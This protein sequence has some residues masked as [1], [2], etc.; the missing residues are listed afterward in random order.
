MTMQ[1][2]QHAR[3]HLE[4]VK[5]YAPY[6]IVVL[7]FAAGLFALHR[8]LAPID[9]RAVAVEVRTIPLLTLLGAFI[10]TLGGYGA[11][12][13]YDWSALRYI[14]KTLPLRTVMLGGFLGYAFGN[15]IG[16]NA[17]SGGAVRYRIYSAL[18][19]DG[20]DVAAIATFASLAY[21]FGAC[22]V[23]L[24]SLAI[25]PAALQTLLPFDP[26]TIRAAAAVC[27]ALLVLALGGL[28]FSGATIKIWRVNV[29]APSP[30]VMAG[31]V[32]FTMLDLGLSSLALYMLLPP[33]ELGFA[34]F[35]AVFC[36]ATMI[37]VL[38]HVP[39][40][41]GV[42]E[43]V[44]L[45]SLPAS[46]PLD[47]AAAALLVFR[48]IYY[49]VPFG[50]ALVL[51]A[52]SE[53][54]AAAPAMSGRMGGA[55]AAM[56]PAA[57]AASAVAPAAL[58]ALTFA[59][60][61]WMLVSALM[62]TMSQR[63]DELELLVPPMFVEGGALLSSVIGAILIIVAHGLARRIADAY[64][65]A[66]IALAAGAAT[67][68]LH[69]LD[70]DR[71]IALACAALILLP[72]RREFHRSA[73][74]THAPF[75]PSWFAL[76]GAVAVSAA[77][78]WFFAH[79][80]AGREQEVWWLLAFD[81]TVP[82]AMRAGL[83]ASLALTAGLVFFALR[84]VTLAPGR[85]TPQDMA[86]AGRII[87]GQPN[88]DAN[89]AFAGDKALMFAEKRDAFVMYAVQNRSWIAF[90]DPV[91]ARDGAAQAAWAFAD[92]ATYAGARPV[93]YEVSEA[94]LPLWIDMG[95]ALHKIGEE[96]VVDLVAF[97]LDGPARKRLRT[98]WNRARRDGL[99]FTMLAPPHAPE[100]LAVLRAIS[101]R[102]LA[103][104]KTREKGF[105]VGRFDPDYLDRFSIM[106]VR[107]RGRPVAFA[108]VI[109]TG[110]RLKSAIDLMRH[111]PDAP[112]GVM[113]FLFTALM[114]HQK[115]EGVARFSLGMA[116]L[117]GLEA[118]RG[119]SL[120]TQFGAQIYRHG[121]HFYNFEGLRHFKEKFD[122]EWRPRYLACESTLPPV[123]PLA[124]VS[125]L[126][127]GGARGVIGR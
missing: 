31:Q 107:E 50:I 36:I 41:V 23:G 27:L 84:P 12:I 78:L 85:P 67:A 60:G 2:G 72:C 20:Y 75:D 87:A 93:F 15:T 11:L 37:G 54:V 58:A 119:A 68:L 6:V 14:R 99:D 82:R 123:K 32:G 71:A 103:G 91:G 48:L 114:L 49:L 30:A 105:S 28:A 94:F 16:L 86:D 81:D 66:Q 53:L 70:Y 76:I 8:L 47:Q 40:G 10:A 42:F 101:D 79:K 63:A 33:S 29:R 120:W 38:S 89:L 44:V 80:G 22:V 118:R 3:P 51:L 126:I 102:W 46:I 83:L 98:A 97:D 1:A 13:G 111:V 112:G 45:A 34:T 43:S 92:A 35:L 9:M 117:S 96:A 7:L 18:G 61:V 69:G 104:K 24:G 21:G 121:G 65:I 90:G 62:P 55:L 108:T 127:A 73:R 88:P 64:L 25:H 95:M 125:I 39:G 124:E 56:R 5:R 52:L 4:R 19:L 110:R 26:S 17:V 59:S 109:G 113:E 106:L 100:T 57:R 116:P 115:A 77:F 74:L 122:P